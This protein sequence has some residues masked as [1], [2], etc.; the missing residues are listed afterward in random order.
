MGPNTGKRSD[1]GMGLQQIRDAIA[2]GVKVST[3]SRV[4]YLLERFAPDL[5]EKLR[6]P[7]YSLIRQTWPGGP[8]NGDGETYFDLLLRVDRERARREIISY[9]ATDDLYTVELLDKYKG[10]SREVAAAVQKWMATESERQRSLYGKHL[11]RLL[12]FSDPE[13]ELQ[14]ALKRIRELLRKQRKPESWDE[15]DTMTRAVLELN[16]PKAADDLADFVTQPAIPIETRY[17]IV[18]W[19]VRRRYQSLPK[20]F[21]WWLREDD[22]GKHWLRNEAE[23]KYGSL[24]QGLAG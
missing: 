3:Y 6:Q 18:D 12:L 23:N 14:P 17:Q 2:G 4:F 10:P 1:T 11:Q 7:S 21:A 19:L 5:P 8:G 13:G 15:L 22:T 16:S 9:Y 24:R 20:I